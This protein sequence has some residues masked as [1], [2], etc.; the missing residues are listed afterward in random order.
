MSRP[1]ERVVVTLDAAAD[2]RTS[3]DTA[4]RL[5]AHTKASLH[6]VF[7]E[8]EELLHLANLPFARQITVGVGAEPLTREAVE[9]QLQAQAERARRD[10]VAAAS[11]HGVNCSFEIVRGASGIAV[12]CASE[13]DLVVAGGQTRPVA[14]HFRVERRW[15]VTKAIAGPVLLARTSWTRQGSVVTLLRDRDAASARLL[16]A[17][18]QIAAA[19]NYMLNVICTA[20]VAGTEGFDD[21]I[22]DRVSAHGVRVEIEVASLDP[23]V[24]HGRLGQLGCRLLA[25]EVG[26]VEGDV[27]GLR[28]VVERFACDMLLVP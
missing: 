3:I 25:L 1:I 14:G 13:H 20:A 21:W 9:L 11:R 19:N 23:G 8:D 15:S 7:I 12:A 26:L 17:A 6:G 5:A 10:L 2:N 18:A 4:V 24:L 22:A 28:Q 16:E 27:H